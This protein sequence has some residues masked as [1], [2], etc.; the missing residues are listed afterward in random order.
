VPKGLLPGRIRQ[1]RQGG[2]QDAPQAVVRADEVVA[3]V[4]ASVFLDDQHAPA[5]GGHPAQGG[6]APRPSA[7]H[8]GEKLHLGMTQVMVNPL[9]KDIAQEVPVGLC[10]DGVLRQAALRSPAHDGDKLHPP[11]PHVP[12][13]PV[14]GQGLFGGRGG[15]RAQKVRL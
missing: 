10:G 14:D 3:G 15:D 12:E 5:D 6:L 13:R 8:F 4:D 11:G 9:V 2:G 1:V 7:R